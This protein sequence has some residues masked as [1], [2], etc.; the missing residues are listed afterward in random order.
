MG[1]LCHPKDKRLAKFWKTVKITTAIMAYEV[2]T[3]ATD[4]PIPYIK[5]RPYI[6]VYIL[7]V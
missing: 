2:P 6:Y 3:Y 4:R 7:L 5:A 1:L